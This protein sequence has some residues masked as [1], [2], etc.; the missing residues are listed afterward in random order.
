MR[1][2]THRGGFSRPVTA[3]E[4]KSGGNINKAPSFPLSLDFSAQCHAGQVVQLPPPPST[5]PALVTVHGAMKM[6]SILPFNRES[7]TN[8][9]H[10]QCRFRAISP[11][12]SLA[13]WLG[14]LAGWLAHH[15][16]STRRATTA[17]LLPIVAAFT[18]A[19]VSSTLSSV[20]NENKR[21]F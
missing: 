3:R 2:E 1:K 6:S 18:H 9:I 17:H 20:E 19:G 4:N 13:R 5:S 7:T 15:H 8:Y 10:H 11:L 14:W 16:S 21:L 12:H